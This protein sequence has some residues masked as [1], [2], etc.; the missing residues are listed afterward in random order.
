MIVK[1]PSKLSMNVLFRHSVFE[2]NSSSCHSLAIDLASPTMASKIVDFKLDKHGDIHIQPQ[3]YDKEA[4]CLKD[5]QSKLPYIIA[6][7]FYDEE[8]LLDVFKLLKQ[9]TACNNIYFK[10]ICLYDEHDIFH[11]E[12]YEQLCFDL[13]YKECGVDADSFHL[14][15]KTTDGTVDFDLIKNVLFNPESI[16]FQDRVLIKD[17]IEKMREDMVNHIKAELDQDKVKPFIEFISYLSYDHI[18]D[19]C[20]NN[21]E[22]IYLFDK[23]PNDESFNLEKCF[24][25]PLDICKQDYVASDK[26]NYPSYTNK[27]HI[28]GYY[29]LNK[30]LNC[31]K[32]FCQSNGIDIQDNQEKLDSMLI[33]QYKIDHNLDSLNSSLIGNIRKKEKIDQLNKYPEKVIQEYIEDRFSFRYPQESN[34]EKYSLQLQV[35]LLYRLIIDWFGLSHKYKYDENNQQ[36]NWLRTVQIIE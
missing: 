26:S 17:K 35:A 5:F 21:D 1:P 24:N 31:L 8:V 6:Q 18:L 20:N 3:Y 29:K 13:K 9:I 30:F 19:M 34:N 32:Q 11:K 2:T 10:S 27:E 23:T 7:V 14:F 15:E 12:A 22:H 33:Q 28:S 36:F 25:Y 16:I 4:F